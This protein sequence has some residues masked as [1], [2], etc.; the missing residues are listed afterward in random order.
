M[1]QALLVIDDADLYLPSATGKAAAKEPLQNLL[2]RASAAGLGLVLTSRRPGDLDYR[3]CAAIDTWFIGKTDETAA[4]KMKPLFERR[5]LGHRNLSRLE[6]G[7]FVMLHDSG[8][9]DVERGSPMIEL[10]KV[11]AAELKAL[12]SQTRPRA[13]TRD[14]PPPR[15]AEP[16]S[17]MTPLHPPR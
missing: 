16:A 7:R 1:P 2:K 3:H 15:K 4:E 14:T 5:P 9:R 6:S 11:E 10:Q 12:A 8:A 13:G 17:E